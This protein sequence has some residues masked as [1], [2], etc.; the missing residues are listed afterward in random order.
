[1]PKRNDKPVEPPRQAKRRNFVVETNGSRRS[2]RETVDWV[3]RNY[4]PGVAEEMNHKTTIRFLDVT[5][6]DLVAIL[7][8][9]LKP[10]VGTA[11]IARANGLAALWVLS[12]RGN[13]LLTRIA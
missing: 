10:K 3:E 9:T 11:L 13:R 4:G 6:R 8:R 7:R 1:M 2:T 12:L 5:L